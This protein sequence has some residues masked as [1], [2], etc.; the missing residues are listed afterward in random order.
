M[1]SSNVIEAYILIAIEPKPVMA[2][3]EKRIMKFRRLY[4]LVEVLGP[5]EIMAKF[6]FRNKEQ[7]IKILD[8]LS[9]IEGVKDYL[10][11]ITTKKL[12]SKTS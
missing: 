8:E 4:E 11:L 5:Y 9:R 2:D 6:R 10:V 12:K 7:L 3:I 1:R